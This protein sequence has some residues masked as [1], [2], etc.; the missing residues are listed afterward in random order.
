MIARWAPLFFF[1]P[2]SGSLASTLLESHNHPEA[3]HTTTSISFFSD[4][5]WM[6]LENEEDSNSESV[7]SLPI[8]SVLA[9]QD[10]LHLPAE[11][12][13]DW[14]KVGS[15]ES[16]HFEWLDARLRSLSNDHFYGSLPAHDGLWQVCILHSLQL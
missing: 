10:K 13:L 2:P 3:Q 4:A 8:S 9:G 16:R 6:A 12:Y 7:D 15:D 11:F 14:L 5:E 1:N